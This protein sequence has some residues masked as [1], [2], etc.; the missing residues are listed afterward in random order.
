M[1][2][3]ITFEVDEFG[4]ELCPK[5]GERIL[6]DE[7]NNCSLCGAPDQHGLSITP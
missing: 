3:P 2:E 5:Y 4:W 7:D 1:T 6:P